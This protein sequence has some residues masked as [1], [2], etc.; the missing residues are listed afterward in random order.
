MSEQKNMIRVEALRALARIDRGS[1][2]PDAAC[3][4]F[5]ESIKPQKGQVV[6]AYWPQPSEFDVHPILERLRQE[7]I[8]CALPVI[9]KD[10]LELGFVSWFEST[11]LKK[12]AKNVYEP[13]MS[14]GEPLL[15]PDIVIVPLLAFDRRGYRLGR[16]GGYYDTTLEVLRGKK[17]VL[18]VGIAY[19]QQA[20]LFNL[21]TEPHDQ[22]LGWVI[23]P[24]RAHY[25]GN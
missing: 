4:L 16:G 5:F 25:F 10:M 2:D 14:P 8:S 6:A 19:A 17:S 23:T 13:V 1:E 15:E 7:G 22:K 24:D 20:C 3:R 12:N 11:A 18:A 9:Q 21:P